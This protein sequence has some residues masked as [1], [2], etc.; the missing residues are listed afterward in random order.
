MKNTDKCNTCKHEKDCQLKYL[1]FE[2]EKEWQV[3]CYEEEK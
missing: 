2:H 3:A 1:N